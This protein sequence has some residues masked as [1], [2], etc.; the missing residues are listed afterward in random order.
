MRQPDGDVGLPPVGTTP[1][2][3]HFQPLFLY[4]SLSG[5]VGAA[6]LLFLARRTTRLRPGDVA[7]LVF[8]W[9]GATRFLLEPLRTNNWLI[10]GIPTASYISAAVVAGALLLL[11]WRHR[12]GAAR[13]EEP[14]VGDDD[15]PGGDAPG[16]EPAGP[17]PAGRPEPAQG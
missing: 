4:E 6:V 14:S 3:A 2:D 17:D 9:Y 12:P 5:L 16:D 8:A 10:G 11:A 7:L 15:G 13:G 1:I